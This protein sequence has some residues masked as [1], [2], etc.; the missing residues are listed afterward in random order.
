MANKTITLSLVLD[1]KGAIQNLEELQGEL[2]KV[3]VQAKKAEESSDKLADSL[4]R[5]EARIKTLGGAINIVGGAV[6]VAVG[7]FVALGLASEETS[8][9]YEELVLSTIAVVDGAKRVQEGYKELNEGLKSFGGV[10]GAAVKAFNAL[11]AAA[12]ANPI[13]ALAVAIGAVVSA[14]LIYNSTSKESTEETEDYKNAVDNLNKS[15]RETKL[16]AGANANSIG[17]LSQ[18]FKQGKITQAQY[19]AQLKELG[20]NLDGINL[21]TE[22]NIKLVNELA[23]ANNNIASQQ[24]NRAKLEGELK[25]A[26]EKN[27]EEGERAVIRLRNE[28]GAL[29][30]AT[31]RYTAQ[32]DA[33]LAKFDAQRKATE[34]SKRAAEATDKEREALVKLD[35]Y[36]S[37]VK[38]EIDVLIE[39]LGG[40]E[41]VIQGP[42]KKAQEDFQMRLEKS[43]RDTAKINNMI[44]ADSIKQQEDAGKRI[45]TWLDV[46]GLQLSYWGKDQAKFFSSELGQAIGG[47]L[48]SA[49][50]LAGAITASID[51]STKEGFEKAKKARIAEL[52][53]SS[54]QAAFSAYGGVVGIPIVGPILAPVAAAAALLA[55][56]NAIN[57]VKASTFEQQ[58]APSNPVSGTS[59]S[60]GGGGSARAL[61]T[62]YMSGGF[63]APPGG[64]TPVLAPQEPLR[65]YVVSGDVASGLEAQTQIQRRRTLGPG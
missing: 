12:I 24:A 42:L 17:A 34:A 65:A 53:I 14:L 40:Y 41:K 44:Y 61:S 57:D 58:G 5:Q 33:I 55:G 50:Q 13:T 26:Q 20:L 2:G 36:I 9:R 7:S 18:A 52:R 19:V 16:I 6:E 48:Q 59:S 21:S 31:S 23:Q 39:A 46:L 22:G 3:G 51:D 4:E 10:A 56:Q 32:R 28:I 54:I 35:P 60:R 43:M 29:D 25:L 64:G 47:A 11:K 37:A 45:T 62:E 8:K 49:T 1:D 63:L 30:V 27:N 38:E 15:L